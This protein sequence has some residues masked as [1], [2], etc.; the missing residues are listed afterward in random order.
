MRTAA[1]TA[2]RRQAEDKQKDVLKD[3]ERDCGPRGTANAAFGR[4]VRVAGGQ[5]GIESKLVVSWP[6]HRCKTVIILCRLILM[7]N[8]RQPFQGHLAGERPP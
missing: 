1:A 2:E 3:S 6:L 5:R 7:E 8:S 4:K